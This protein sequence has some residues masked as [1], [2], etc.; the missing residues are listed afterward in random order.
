MNLRIT[1]YDVRMYIAFIALVLLSCSSKPT[2][3]TDIT[4]K[5]MRGFDEK[6]Q[7]EILLGKI[8]RNDLKGTPYGWFDSNYTSAKLDTTVLSEIQQHWTNDIRIE[9]VMGTWCSD[10]KEQIPHLMK[11]LDAVNFPKENVS[12]YCVDRTKHFPFGAP[13]EEEIEKIPT[14]FFN[15]GEQRL[16]KFVEVP[17]ESLE[18]DLLNILKGNY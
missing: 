3:K 1:M 14:I 16:G 13:H 12:L 11:I 2:M 5:P 7:Q 9:I 17:L 4:A 18:K 15:N 10:S 8:L 6:K